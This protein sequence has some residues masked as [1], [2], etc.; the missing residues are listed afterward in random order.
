MAERT[1]K[2]NI[3][4]KK[5]DST[6]QENKPDFLKKKSFSKRQKIIALIVIIAFFL[7]GTVYAAVFREKPV[8]LAMN[9]VTRLAPSEFATTVNTTGTIEA[10]KDIDVYTTQTAPVKQVLVKEGDTVTEGQV[11]AYLDDNDLKKQIRV[12]ETSAGVTAENAA[13]QVQSAKNKYNA[14]ARA[15][16]QGNNSAIVSAENAVETAKNQWDSAEK[17]WADY[18]RSIDEGYLTD[19]A[20]ETDTSI[21]GEQSIATA[22]LNVKQAQE[23][24][25][26]AR[27]KYSQ[28]ANDA[29]RYDA[30]RKALRIKRDDKQIEVSSSQRDI[31]NSDYATAK[32]K[33][34]SIQTELDQVEYEISNAPEPVDPLLT[35][36]ASMLEEQLSTAESELQDAE[37]DYNASGDSIDTAN[38]ELA[39]IQ[40]QLADAEANYSR[41]DGD[42]TSWEQQIT[43]REDSLAQAKLVLKQAKENKNKDDNKHKKTKKSREDQL[44]TYRQ[45]A[46]S[47]KSSYNQA[48]RS[49][50]AT[51]VAAGDELQSYEDS[52]RTSKASSNDDVTKVEL[53]NLYQDLNDMTIRA[54]MSGTVTKVFA[55]EGSSATGSLFKIENLDN[56]IITTE[57]KAFDLQTVRTG[58]P[59]DIKTDATENEVFHGRLVSISDSATDTSSVADPVNSTSSTSNDPTFKAKVILENAP[60]NLLAGMKAQLNIITAEDQNVY[61]V[62][63]SSVIENKDGSKSIL[64]AEKEDKGDNRY[65]LKELP[66][67]TSLENDL[68]IVIEGNNLKDGMLVINDP[69]NFSEGA[70]IELKNQPDD[71][72][73]VYAEDGETSS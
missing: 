71:A 60:E 13:A 44:S 20:G 40:N 50:K 29:A 62:P 32:A 26:E 14:A 2:M 54:P 7:S 18:K 27:R 31:S 11:L 1:S 39:T 48:L 25:D 64:V 23:L 56:L 69:T 5:D 67:S 34:D 42:K 35:Q 46:D 57:L 37:R 52:V 3:F 55:N 36:K 66:V 45:N 47:A 51:R 33:V 8:A 6:N 38:R 17:T 63:F 59:V 58:M 30:E 15:L 70:L 4:S 12:K 22:E 72:T 10:A 28:A 53:A 43:S 16:N 9:Q 68:N 21:A 24:L 73:E 61:A 19:I 49:L 41:A 65:R